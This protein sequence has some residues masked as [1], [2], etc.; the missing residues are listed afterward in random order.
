MCSC[1]QR[2]FL[3]LLNQVSHTARRMVQI[4]RGQVLIY[5][6]V[7][8]YLRIAHFSWAP[9]ACLSALARYDSE[10]VSF[11]VL[12]VVQSLAVFLTRSLVVQRDTAVSKGDSCHSTCH[13]GHCALAGCL[14]L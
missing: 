1:L 10:A 13:L 4:Q 9:A 7:L 12:L 6:V 5:N 3:L 11:L 2:P 14:D 8:S